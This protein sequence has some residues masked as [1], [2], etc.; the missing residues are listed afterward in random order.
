MYRKWILP[1]GFLALA[2]VAGAWGYWQHNE[3]RLLRVA[4]ENSYY[5]AFFNLADHVQNAEVLLGKTLVSADPARMRDLLEQIRQRSNQALDNLTQLPVEDELLGKTAKF[6]TQLG[7]YSRTLSEQV[8]TGKAVSGEQW[9]TLNRLYNQASSLNAEL[10]KIYAETTGG[11][12]GFYELAAAGS[13]RLAGEGG[14]TAGAGFREID[15]QMQ[16]YPTLIYDGPFSDHVER[17]NGT[18]IKGKE[19]SP[20]RAREVA[21]NYLDTGEDEDVIARVT[22]ELEGDIPAYRV[23]MTRRVQGKVSGEPAVADVSKKGGHLVWMLN[24]R[25]V[26]SAKLDAEQAA[27]RARKYLEKHGYDS[28]KQSYYQRNDNTITFNYAYTQEGIIIYPDLVKVTVALD[29]GQVL[30]VDARTYLMSHRQRKLPGAKLSEQQAR[31]LVNDR[32]DIEG[33]G[34]LAL[35]P[36]ETGKEKLT[37]EF[38]GT[39]G[40]ETYLVYINALDGREENVLR[41]IDNQ[42]GVLTM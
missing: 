31:D 39:L 1:L 12:F 13:R 41:L 26:D 8:A 21:M 25:D 24:P 36:T 20:G 42:D 19:I 34:R 3:N 15:N 40:E 16:K 30:A 10:G 9:E 11:R 6:I 14:T 35:I 2:L 4:L 17:G 32:L 18:L 29:N 38:K 27:E 5:R 28:M 22:G 7:D 37:W 23:Q 33:P